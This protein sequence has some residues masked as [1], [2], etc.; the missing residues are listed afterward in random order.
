MQ[1]ENSITSGKKVIAKVKIFVH[2]SNADTDT[3]PDTDIRAMTLAPKTFIP[4]R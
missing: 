1:Y 4:A 2:A 3:D